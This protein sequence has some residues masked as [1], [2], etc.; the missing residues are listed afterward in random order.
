MSLSKSNELLRSAYQ[1]AQRE[2]KNTNWEAFINNL[3][4]ELLVQA[5]LSEDETNENYILRA[6][7]TPKTYRIVKAE[8]DDFDWKLSS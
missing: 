7:V 2:G 6:T 5:G 3:R 1:I 4:K 8:F